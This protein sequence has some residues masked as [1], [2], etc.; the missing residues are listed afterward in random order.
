ME[1]PRGFMKR[2]MKAI[3][4]S[5]NKGNWDNVEIKN[6]RGKDR[7]KLLD[8]LETTLKPGEF[9]LIIVDP[10]YKLYCR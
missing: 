9:S 7:S 3:K 1:R 4:E 10:I 6:L 8:Y 2:R 5:Y